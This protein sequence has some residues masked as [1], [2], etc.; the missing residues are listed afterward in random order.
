MVLVAMRCTIFTRTLQLDI[1]ARRLGARGTCR[2][3]ESQVQLQFQSRDK[4]IESVSTAI[5]RTNK[6][7]GNGVRGTLKC[8]NRQIRLARLDEK[9][10]LKAPF[11]LSHSSFPFSCV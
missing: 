2:L 9:I 6:P 3:S 8:T 11:C 10:K 1:L 4:L 5:A 7:N